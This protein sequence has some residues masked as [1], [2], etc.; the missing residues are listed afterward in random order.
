[1]AR[2]HPNYEEFKAAGPSEHFPLRTMIIRHWEHC[3]NIHGA[4]PEDFGMNVRGWHQKHHPHCQSLPSL[5]LARKVDFV[6]TT[7]KDKFALQNMMF[8]FI[9]G[10]LLDEVGDIGR[11]MKT[12]Q[13]FYYDT[14]EEVLAAYWT[15]SEAQRLVISPVQILDTVEIGANS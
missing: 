6:E 14:K 5:E 15:L 12:D 8:N 2:K 3:E 7:P 1:M 13:P 4:T 11:Y 10:E 9:C